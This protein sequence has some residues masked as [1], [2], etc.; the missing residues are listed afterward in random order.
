MIVSWVY[1]NVPKGTANV[2]FVNV[3]ARAN[4]F[5]LV[6]EMVDGG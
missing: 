6:R 3:A 2:Y 5:E 4:A 1:F